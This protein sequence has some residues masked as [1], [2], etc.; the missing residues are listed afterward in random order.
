MK[1]FSFDPGEGE[2]RDVNDRDDDDAE[3]HRVGDLFTRRKH[4]LASLLAVESAPEFVL[5]NSELTH[6]VLN[7]HNRA[8]DDESEIDRAQAHQV[9]R[10]PELHHAGQGKEKGEWNSCG[11]DE[12]RAPISQ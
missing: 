2:N 11:N 12:S 7:N 5:P 1:H 6:H 9:S 4:H 3:K 10:Y 8:V